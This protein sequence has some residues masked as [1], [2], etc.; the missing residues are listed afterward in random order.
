MLSVLL[1]VISK[2]KF[3][4]CNPDQKTRQKEEEV[5]KQHQGMD[6]P[7]V[8]QVPEGS[9]KRRKMKESGCEVISGAPTFPVVKE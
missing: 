7:G 6:R 2:A 1:P 3:K 4:N 9:G 8:C 5:G